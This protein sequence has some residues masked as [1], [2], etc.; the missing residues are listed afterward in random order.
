MF[1]SVLFFF[2]FLKDFWQSRDLFFPLFCT[3]HGSSQK[4]EPHNLFFIFNFYNRLILPL[5]FEF[6]FFHLTIYCKHP[7]CLGHWKISIQHFPLCCICACVCGT[8]L[9]H[10]LFNPYSWAFRLFMFYWCK[11]K[12]SRRHY[13]IYVLYQ[14]CFFFTVRIHE[15]ELLSDIESF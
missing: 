15:L 12:Y 14:M 4:R 6:A 11:N 13:S 2:F 7:S 5:Y 3:F 9:C 8:C 10:N 1:S